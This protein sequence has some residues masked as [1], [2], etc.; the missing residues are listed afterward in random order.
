MKLKRLFGAIAGLVCAINLV[1]VARA[2]LAAEENN[3]CGRMC[4]TPGYALEC[5]QHPPCVW[6]MAQPLIGEGQCIHL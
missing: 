5:Y 4:F 6:C 3:G 1:A 2:P